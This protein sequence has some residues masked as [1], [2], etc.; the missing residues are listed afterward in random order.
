MG[1]SGFAMP[2]EHFIWLTADGPLEASVASRTLF[3]PPYRDTFGGRAERVLGGT[4]EVVG[5]AIIITGVVALDI[6][7]NNHYYYPYHYAY[8]Y[9]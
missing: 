4:A 8:P 9:R 2:N 3:P 7:L 6:L 5:G 1:P